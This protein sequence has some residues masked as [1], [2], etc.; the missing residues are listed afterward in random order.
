MVVG[1]DGRVLLEEFP[2]GVSQASRELFLALIQAAPEWQFK[3]FVSTA[4]AEQALERVRDFSRF[5]NV[6]IVIKQLPNRLLNLSLSLF[7]FPRLDQLVGGADI[8]LSPN[9]GFVAVS[10]AKL[11]VLL[12]D[13]TFVTY[14]R[15][16]KPYTRV[17]LAFIQANRLLRSAAH[18]LTPSQHSK[19]SALETFPQLASASQ[20]TSKEKLTL[21]TVIPFGPPRAPQL[22]SDFLQQVKQRYHLPDAFCLTV[23]TLEPRKNIRTLIEAWTPELGQLVMFGAPGWDQLP[24]HPQVTYLGYVTQD[25]KWAILQLAQA[26]IYPTVA[27]GFG[28]PLLEAFAAGV[29]V[30]AGAHTSLVEVGQQ[31]VLWTNVHN[32]TTLRQ[33]VQSVLTDVKLRQLLIERGREVLTQYSWDTTAQQLKQALAAL[34]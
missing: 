22:T 4:H 12:H 32:Q 24:S 20:E 34:H 8:W 30:V 21:V 15:L 11:V 18:I 3:L 17:W 29:P 7:K 5:Q 2:S 23:G 10:S 14:R 16:L 9:I 6:E 19:T 26:M 28:L 33:A 25:E 1:L 13:T 31:A 27:E